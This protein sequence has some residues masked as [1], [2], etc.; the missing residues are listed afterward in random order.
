MDGYIDAFGDQRSGKSRSALVRRAVRVCA[1]SA[2]THIAHAHHIWQPSLRRLQCGCVPTLIYDRAKVNIS[3]L[4]AVGEGRFHDVFI[5]LSRE[6]LV[7]RALGEQVSY[8]T[9]LQGLTDLPQLLLH[10][11]SEG[12]AHLF[13]ILWPLGD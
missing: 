13:N 11:E 4:V 2:G 9:S 12:R 6:E 5:E 7:E 10:A 3:P 8:H 1:T